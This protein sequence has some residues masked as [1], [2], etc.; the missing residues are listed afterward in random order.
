MNENDKIIE[1]VIELMEKYEWIVLQ[2]IV[3]Y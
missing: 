2:D 3:E 1:K